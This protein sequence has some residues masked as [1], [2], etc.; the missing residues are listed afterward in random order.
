MRVLIAPQEFKGSLSAAAAAAAMAKGVRAVFPGVEIDEAPLSDG[1]PGFVAAMLAARGGTLVE[2]PASDPL[3][4]P[5]RAGWALMPDGSGVIEM[6]AASGL[7]LVAPGERD[8]LRATSYGTGELIAA[9]LDRGC[10]EI[11]AGIGGSATTDGGA[12]AM[13]AL[14]GRLFDAEGR[15]LPPGGAALARL[16]RIDLAER[17]PLLAQA[18]LRVA[19][20]V[21]NTLCGPEGAAAVFAPQKGASPGD[22]RV[23]DAALRHFASIAMRDCGIDVLPLAGGGAAGGLGAGLATIAGATLEPGFPLV[24]EVV[25]L[26][27]R[28]AA[29]DIVLTGEGRLDAQTAYGKTVAGVAAMARAQGRPVGAVAGRVAAEFDAAGTLDVVVEAASPAMPVEAAMRDAATLV[30]AAAGRAVR[31]LTPRPAP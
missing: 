30:A 26:E 6:A 24:A 7:V 13:Q 9:A 16:A 4:R 29:A 28:I 19:C 22:V 2:T 31:E 27:R 21:T 11:I 17:H 3:M 12:G 23:L 5:V 20:D 15:D 25:E 18:R 10:R 8:A 1:G 14:G